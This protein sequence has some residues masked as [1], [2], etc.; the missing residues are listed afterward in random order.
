MISLSLETIAQSVSGQLIGDNMIIDQVSIDSREKHHKGLFVAIQ[1]ENFDGHDY[2]SK[3][4]ESGCIA[5]LVSKKTT[6]EIPQILVEDTSIALGQVAKHIRQVVNPVV[7]G[8]TGSAGKTT[9]K[10]M[11][12]SILRN[13]GQVLATAGNFNNHIGVPLTLLRLTEKEQFAVVE[14]G[15]NHKNEIA[16]CCSIAKPNISTINNVAAAHIEGFGSIEG[17]AQAKAEIYQALDAD[18]IAVINAD[19]AFSKQWL[20]QE[21]SY[22]KISVSGHK[23]ADFVADNITLD[24]KGH[25]AFMLNHQEQS[26]EIK[27]NIAG[28]H[29]VLNALVAAALAKSAGASW[30]SIQQGLQNTPVVTGRLKQIQGINDCLVI[31]DTYN[32]SVISIK[33]AIDYLVSLNGQNVLVLGDMAEL[34]DD[35]QK[36][37]AEIGLYAKH[38]GIQQVYLLGHEVKATAAAFGSDAHIYQQKELLIKDLLKKINST[39]NILIKGSRSARME[40][41]VQALTQDEQNT[42]EQ[43]GG[44]H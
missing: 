10:E 37:H 42:A 24:S 11:T 1:G 5:A 19:D 44:C 36:Y 35:S 38:K 43:R 25:A 27:L 32:A 18:G 41:V 8:I 40:I 9:V 23:D 3:A 6:L 20:A 14:M 30:T 34:G 13:E 4:I 15:A 16:Y 21:A 33:A 22:Q 7:I 2:V 17:V 28:K 29:N 26:T 39:Q 12:A 31:D